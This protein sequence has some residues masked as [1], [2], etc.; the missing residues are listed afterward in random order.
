MEVH[1]GIV[2]IQSQDAL[3]FSYGIVNLAQLQIGVRETLFI[4]IYA[5]DGWTMLEGLFEKRDSFGGAAG[6]QNEVAIPELRHSG[7]LPYTA[8]RRSGQFLRHSCLELLRP[9]HIPASPSEHQR[10][11]M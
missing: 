5:P 4:S 2:W 3:V 8:L 9:G 7:T 6:L 1:Q 11:A 10:P